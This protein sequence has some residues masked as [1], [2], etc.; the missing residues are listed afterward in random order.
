M[1]KRLRRMFCDDLAIELGTVNTLIYQAGEGLVLNEPSLVAVHNQTTRAH[2]RTDIAAV[3]NDAKRMLGRMPGSY[4]AVKPVQDGMIADFILTEKMLQYFMHHIQR[5]RLMRWS[6]RMLICVRCGSTEVER[7]V[8]REV[9]LS[10]GAREVLLIEEPL[11]A[12]LGADVPVSDAHGSMIVDLGGGTTQ[13]ALISMNGVV[14]AASLRM[15]GDHLNKSITN[16]IRRKYLLVISETTA[17][18]IKQQLGSAYPEEQISELEVGGHHLTGGVP[19]TLVLNSDEIYEVLR[20]PLRKLAD[21][22]RR[23]LDQTPPEL[24]ID[25]RKRGIMLTGGGAL[26]KG[27][28]RMLADEIGMPVIIAD[29]PLTCV[30]RGAGKALSMLHKKGV[31]LFVPI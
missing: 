25:V 26:L 30:A 7:R 11:A 9:A 1:L 22:L 4:S 21:P 29:E 10:A 31:D 18:H 17:E 6:P 2:N 5:N 24:G 28:D 3:G 27:V 15:G 19:C 23:V 12:A 8:I 20:Q 16:Y 13:A 14:H